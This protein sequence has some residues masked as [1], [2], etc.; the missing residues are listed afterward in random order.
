[1]Y[2]PNPVTD[3]PASSTSNPQSQDLNPKSRI[4]SQ[5]HELPAVK[6][7][8]HHLRNKKVRNVVFSRYWLKD[9]PQGH[10]DKA[11][12]IVKLLIEVG[13]LFYNIEACGRVNK[14]SYSPPEFLNNIEILDYINDAFRQ[15][16]DHPTVLAQLPL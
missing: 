8:L 12:E 3:T 6:G 9:D 4:R 16:G 7:A 15:E 11:N 5:G 1:M 10:T 14:I 2:W 13:Y